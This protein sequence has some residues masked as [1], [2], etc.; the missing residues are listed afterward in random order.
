[1]AFPPYRFYPDKQVY[2]QT[3]VSH[4]RLNDSVTVHNA[5]T[6]WTEKI[7]PKNFTVCALHSGRNED[8]FN[9]FAT[10]DWIAYQGAPPEGLTG[11]IQLQK[12]WSGTNCAD[13]TF[14]KVGMVLT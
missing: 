1:V 9:P 12:W 5:A 8:K 4:I 3:T 10:I 13:V 11:T 14:P 2:V 7:N 6:S